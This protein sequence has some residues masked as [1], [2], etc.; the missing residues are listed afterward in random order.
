MR[1]E[2]GGGGEAAEML[3]TSRNKNGLIPHQGAYGKREEDGPALQST[4]EVKKVFR[5]EEER[6]EKG[7][8]VIGKT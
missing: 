2:K 6:T 7:Q 5:R 4:R 3:K 1:P 8:G